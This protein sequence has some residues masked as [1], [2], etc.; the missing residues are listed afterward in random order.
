[1][2]TTILFLC[3]LPII[4]AHAQRSPV[5]AGGDGFGAGGSIA[6]SVG[7]V[8]YTVSASPAATLAA[9]V[10]QPYEVSTAIGLPETSGHF[11]LVVAPNPTGGAVLLLASAPLPANAHYRLTDA[12]SRTLAMGVLQP[13][14]SVVPVEDRSAGVYFLHVLLGHDPLRTFRIL[15]H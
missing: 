14:R 11:G 2:R 13:T 6:W 8:A 5:A 12:Q 9:G 4:G 15:K 10:Q 1:M 3:S 7:Q